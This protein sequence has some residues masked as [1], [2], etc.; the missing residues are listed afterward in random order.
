MYKA[1]FN[2]ENLLK[3]TEKRSQSQPLSRVASVYGDDQKSW[4]GNAPQKKG[5]ET[6]S[7]FGFGIHN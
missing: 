6:E 5:R 2:S 3:F 4:E 7:L 1:W